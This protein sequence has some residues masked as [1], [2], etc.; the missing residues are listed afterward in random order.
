[1]AEY[2]K[3]HYD[4]KS[5]VIRFILGAEVMN[6]TLDAIDHV[7]NTAEAIKDYVTALNANNPKHGYFGEYYFSPER[8][9]EGLGFLIYEIQ[10]GALVAIE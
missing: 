2:F 7:G 6:L 5:D 4:I 9:A 1:M 3:S 8:N 10:D